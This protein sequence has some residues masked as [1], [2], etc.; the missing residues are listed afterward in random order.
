MAITD[1]RIGPG[2]LTIDSVEFGCTI[3]AAKLV[4]SH[5]DVDTRRRFCD[6]TDPVPGLKTS[7]SLEGE[8]GQDWEDKT[9][10]VEYCKN[11]NGMNSTFTLELDSSAAS[12]ITYSGT[13]Q[14]R[15]V[16][17]GGEAGEELVSDFA[18]PV[19][20]EPVRA[21]DPA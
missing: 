13:C 2:K 15:A 5:E 19:L 21:G 9:G 16:E 7:W 11:N 4:P 10:I 17:I 12:P 8:L 1:S 14:I 6:S 3:F 20:G 18:F